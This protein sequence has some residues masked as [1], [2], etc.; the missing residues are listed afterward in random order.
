[1]Q[2]LLVG[3]PRAAPVSLPFRAL[4]SVTA[5]LVSVAGAIIIGGCGSG[6]SGGGPT[7][8]PTATVPRSAT[9]KFDLS[10]AVQAPG[11]TSSVRVTL[12]GAAEDGTDVTILINRTSDN[13]A[14]TQQVSFSIPVRVAVGV[15]LEVQFYTGA[16]GT[17]TLIG[18][19]TTT[20]SIL[21]DGSG[22]GTISTARRIARVKVLPNQ[23]VLVGEPTELNFEARDADGALIA[24]APGSAVFTV[25]SADTDRLS[26]VG[27]TRAVGQRPGS[28]DV[29]V[30]VDGIVSAPENITI[31]SNANIVITPLTVS[32][33]AL[34][35]QPFTA[36]VIGAPDTSVIWS[37]R[38]GA[39]GGTISSE[40]RYTAPAQRGVFHVDAVSVYD[41]TKTA[42]ATVTVT[43]F[44]TVSPAAATVTLR[45]QQAFTARVVGLPDTGVT[46]SL[47]EGSAG[48]AV[49]SDGA[50]TAPDLAGTYHLIATS[51]EDA[52][53]QATI[54]ITVQ[55]GSGTIIIE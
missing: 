32:V 23:S 44:V 25:I 5:A 11:S 14:Y 26:I 52:S 8:T 28:A 12:R 29:T 41:G 49:T 38:E 27:G 33:N 2:K 50:Y 13:A 45:Q 18:A 43:P 30:A 46:W 31:R 51:H 6:G 42:S 47:L 54:T 34:A 9:A 3:R 24:V 35:E 21:A 17:G 37:V 20:V 19:T 55:A 10:W 53:V 48:G 7:P 36:Q 39:D 16:D 1:M 40:G 15:T 22:I 4:L